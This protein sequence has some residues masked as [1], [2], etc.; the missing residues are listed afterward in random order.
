MSESD[1]IL[2]G[3]YRM[4]AELG[5]GGMAEVNLAVASGPAGFNKLVVIKQLR[6]NLSDDPDFLN[7]FLDEARLAARLNH[8]N[9][10]HTYEVVSDR[11]QNFIA[12]EY[13]DGQPLNR[14][15]RD[16]SKAGGLPLE[17]SLRIISDALGGLHYAH[18]LADYDGTLLNVVHRDVS[19]HNIF[20]TY[21]GQTKVVDFGIAKALN[22][23]SETRSGVIKGK[24]SYMSPE[25][26]RS[27]PLDRRSDVFAAGIILWEAVTGQ[28]LWKGLADVTVLQR[29]MVNQPVPSPREVKPDVRKDLEEICIKALAMKPEDRYATA[30][31]MQNEIENVLIEMKRRVTN[32]DVG[33]LLSEKFSA[34]RAEIRA[35]IDTQLKNQSSENSRIASLAALS[36]QSQTLSA[37]DGTPVSGQLRQNSSQ[38]ALEPVSS[39]G[40]GQSPLGAS[41]SLPPP[42]R[43][44]STAQ[45]NP[46]ASGF[47][48]AAALV[49]GLGLLGGGAWFLK[50]A[51]PAAAPSPP[52]S[53]APA[54]GKIAINLRASPPGAKL[55]LDD[56]PLSGNPY[57]GFHPKDSSKHTLRIEADGYLSKT[58]VVTF[59]A[60]ISLDVELE[61]AAPAPTPSAS[62][63][64]VDA[65]KN[66]GK[67][68]PPQQ[69][70]GARPA[71][72]TKTPDP[73]PAPTGTTT[74]KK[75]NV[76]IDT[77]NPWK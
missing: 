9:V 8:P 11:Q 46:P 59:E 19:P 77:D 76:K 7:M 40:T 69:G 6:Q 75:P 62:T 60:D 15:V 41:L 72:T 65:S 35:I 25:Q 1:P 26:S 31:D 54:L 42:P 20:V 45:V 10:V 47:P 18:E 21:E 68:K 5:R 66:S 2:A 73:P 74:G 16:F 3:K 27:E 22:S 48:R 58:R 39:T 44:S 51:T 33:K 61:K 38:T 23:S 30:A 57:A 17:I 12:M 63:E 71:E 13:L 34:E 29:L 53:A 28:R 14:I 36:P 37:G 50:P 70:G 49:L 52:G 43:E 64:P 24:I 56:E 32:R 4:I 67:K 55:F